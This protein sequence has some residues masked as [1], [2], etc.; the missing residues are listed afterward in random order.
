[1]TTPAPTIADYKTQVHPVWCPGCGDFGVLTCLYRV[2]AG[3]S[4]K[5][6]ETTIVSG[7]GCSSRLPAYVKAYGF[8]TVHGRVLPVATGVK[9]ANP[10]LKVF[11][12]A[13]DGDAFSIGAGHLPHTA[14]RNPD[15]TYIVMDNEIYGLTK[16][17]VSATSDLNIEAGTNPY[18][19]LEEPLNPMLLALAYNISFVARGYS[20]KP[21]QLTELFRRGLEHRGFSFIEVI[22][23]CTTFNDIYKSTNEL[24]TEVDP[25]HDVTDRE[26][27]ITLALRKDCIPLG[28][29]YQVEKPTLQDRID[30]VIQKAKSQQ[31]EEAT[32]EALFNNF[33]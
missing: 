11:A 7:I 27:A 19:S 25:D 6:E 12:V 5:P 33:T 2:L 13:G 20:A 10:E 14:R 15:I 3:K 24:I 16:G 18:G 31:K 17:Q 32:L 21:A 22:S 28:V 29:Y 30:G 4:F 23:P 1:M 9:V 26:K 8:H